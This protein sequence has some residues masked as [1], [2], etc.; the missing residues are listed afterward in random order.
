MRAPRCALPQG[1]ACYL[2]AVPDASEL[3]NEIETLARQAK[4]A[5]R[6]LANAPTGQKNAVLLRAAAALRGPEG[7]EVVLANQKDLV[8]AAERGLSSAMVDRL[9]LDRARVDAIAEGVESVATLPDP[10]GEVLEQRKLGNGLAVAR[11]RVPIGL[12]GIIY[13]SRPNVT[14]D[15]AALCIKSGNAVLLRGGSEAFNSNRAIAAIF[16]TA[17]RQEG[18]PEA[19]ACLLPTTD[20]EATLVMIGLDGIVD[21]VIPR[22]GEALI[23][24]V[25]Q[26]A[27]VPVIQHYKGVCHVY[28]DADADIDMAEAIIVNAKVQ[29]PGVCN[30]AE[31]L[32]VDA[33]IA[34]L[35][36]PRVAQTL[37]D[38]KVALRAD[39]R[40]RVFI[41][42]AT[43][44]TETD[45]DTEYSDLILNVAIV[46]GVDGAHEHIAR[47]GSNHT[48]AIVTRDKAKGERFVREADASLVLMN[49]ST[50]FNDGFQLGLGA[51]MGISTSKLHAYGP[52]G[53]AELCTLKWIAYGDGQI[54]N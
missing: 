34:P 47:H 22:G 50:R 16:A 30:S 44:A 46:D 33:A 37:G 21:L 26:N 40:A 53:L 3:R 36:L 39:A 35:F 25:S 51:E 19:A 24:F 31:T 11:M 13:E 48:E 23:R 49:A 29:R 18:L 42:E 43:L 17:L 38:K 2:R 12:I 14:A 8:V 28:V 27:R 1:E 45:F 20:R 9:R 5:A 10:V 4:R 7:D 15:A 6:A 41:P 32:L 52:M 54:R